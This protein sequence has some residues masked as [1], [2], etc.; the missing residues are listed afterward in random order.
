MANHDLCR[1]RQRALFDTVLFPKRD[2]PLCAKPLGLCHPLIDIAGHVLDRIASQTH[3]RHLPRYR[4]VQTD[5]P[6]RSSCRD[7]LDGCRIMDVQQRETG[8]GKG[9]KENEAGGSHQ[10]WRLA[11]VARGFKSSRRAGYQTSPQ[12]SQTYL[13]AHILAVVKIVSNT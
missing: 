13:L 7:L 5:G 10:R 1:T 11:D 9:R 3:S 6:H 2:C 4:L 12:L 8:C